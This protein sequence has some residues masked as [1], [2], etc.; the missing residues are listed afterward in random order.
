ML[1]GLL[2][3]MKRFGALRKALADFFAEYAYSQPAPRN[4]MSCWHARP[5]PGFRRAFVWET[6]RQARKRPGG[7]QAADTPNGSRIFDSENKLVYTDGDWEDPTIRR[8]VSFDLTDGTDLAMAKLFLRNRKRRGWTMNGFKRFCQAYL[9]RRV[10]LSIME[11]AAEQLR[12]K[13]GAAKD[14]IAQKLVE[15]IERT[16]PL[17]EKEST[18]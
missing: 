18:R 16:C 10:P 15:E 11:K 2:A 3:G 1:R 6:D 4:P 7:G 9:E 14:E 13:T 8:V 5:M 12:G 17:R